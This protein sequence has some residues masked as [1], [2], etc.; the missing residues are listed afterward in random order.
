WLP[1]RSGRL[2]RPTTMLLLV[3]AGG[4]LVA[5]GLGADPAFARTVVWVASM[6]LW[7]LPAYLV[8]VLASPRMSRLAQ[9]V[10]ARVL[11]VLVGVVAVGDVARL[12]GQAHLGAGDFLFGWLAIHQVGFAWRDGQLSFRPRVWAPV[13]LGGFAAL[14]ALTLAGPYSISMI[15][16]S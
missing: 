11:A 3:L 9:P 15:D 12:R 8:V 6:P 4:A 10:G 13:L 14:V 16:V 2:V 1:D 5:R 7:F